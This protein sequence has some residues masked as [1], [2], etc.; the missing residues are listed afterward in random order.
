M[1]AFPALRQ[2]SSAFPMEANSSLRT[3]H[4]R[5]HI[6]TRRPLPP[7]PRAGAILAAVIQICY[8]RV[9]VSWFAVRTYAKQKYGRSKY[10]QVGPVQTPSSFDLYVYILLRSALNSA[11]SAHNYFL[12][13]TCGSPTIVEFR[14]GNTAGPQAAN[15]GLEHFLYVPGK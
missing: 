3:S 10:L 7:P 1:A 2:Y 14:T 6:D 11:L 15:S 12:A 13:D 9:F 8:G 4:T 5:C